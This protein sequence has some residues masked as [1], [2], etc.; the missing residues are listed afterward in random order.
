[1]GFSICNE[2]ENIIQLK[3]STQ[4]T[5]NNFFMKTVSSEDISN[6]ENKVWNDV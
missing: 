4:K 2:F 1:M 3:T 5:A 6:F